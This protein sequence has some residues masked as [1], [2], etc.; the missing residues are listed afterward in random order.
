MKAYNQAI[1]ASMAVEVKDYVE[2]LFVAI[3][4]RLID[5]VDSSVCVHHTNAWHFFTQ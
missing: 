3:S 1:V 2:E 4:K 5:E